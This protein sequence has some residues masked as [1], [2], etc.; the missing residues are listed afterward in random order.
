MVGLGYAELRNS[1]PGILRSAARRHG[2]IFTLILDGVADFVPSVNDEVACN[3][4]ISWLRSISVEFNTPILC[5]IHSNEGIKSGDDGRGWLG[6]EL[7]RKA[8]SNLLLK[9]HGESGPR[10]VKRP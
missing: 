8:E 6:K 10:P 9:K 5:V 3:A 7:T 1:L 4:F 2:G